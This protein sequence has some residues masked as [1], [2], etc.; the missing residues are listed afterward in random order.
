[1]A[2]PDLDTADAGGAISRDLKRIFVESY[3]GGVLEARTW[4]MDEVVLAVLDLELTPAERT[5]VAAGRSQTVRETRN[6]FQL[7][8]GA[9]F[10]AAVERA[11]GRRVTTFLSETNVEPPF[12]VELFRLAPRSAREM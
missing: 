2:E 8:I 7:A 6:Q 12:A 10:S 11:T 1:M 3:G 9:S 5:L 4:M